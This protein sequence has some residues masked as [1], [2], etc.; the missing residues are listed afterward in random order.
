MIKLSLWTLDHYFLHLNQIELEIND[1]GCTCT[2][3]QPSDRVILGRTIVMD[4]VLY[5]SA[6]AH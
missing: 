3:Q 6:W 1:S 4:D 5:A 2:Y